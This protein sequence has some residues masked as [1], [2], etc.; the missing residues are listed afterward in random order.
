[1]KIMKILKNSNLKTSLGIRALIA[2]LAGCAVLLG[3]ANLALGQ[4][5]QGTAKT[6]TGGA[7]DYKFGTS[8]NWNPSGA[9]ASGSGDIAIWDTNGLTGNIGGNVLQV[10]NAASNSSNPGMTLQVTGNHTNGLSVI[11]TGSGNPLR[12]GTNSLVIAS[13]SG[14]VSLGNGGANAFQIALVLGA[15]NNNF[16]TN[17]SAYPATINSDVYWVMGG[18][19]NHNIT[20]CGSGGWN[21]YNQW[22]PNNTGSGGSVDQMIINGTGTVTYAP[23]NAPG[24]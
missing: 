16:F 4:L 5:N 19:N 11:A 22:D 17:N 9:P 20:L 23:T 13:G 18:G 2:K 15:G 12:L 6:W 8:G 21:L 1:M 14:P 24:I 3:A 10:T 7:G